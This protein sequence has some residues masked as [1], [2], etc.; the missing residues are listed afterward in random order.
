M[1]G[2]VGLGDIDGRA[3]RAQVGVGAQH[4]AHI[5]GAGERVEFAGFF[6]GY[7]DL[8]VVDVGVQIHLSLVQEQTGVPLEGLHIVQHIGDTQGG[9]IGLDAAVSQGGI[10]SFPG[11]RG[12]RVWPAKLT[13]VLLR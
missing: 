7:A 3:G 1:C 11:R 2:P 12:G 8:L 4:G 13:T 6:A 9:E 5:E 10:K